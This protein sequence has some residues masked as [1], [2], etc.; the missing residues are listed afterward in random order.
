LMDLGLQKIRLLT[1]NPRRLVGLSAYG[2]E[3]VEMVKLG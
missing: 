1:S 3:V 2:L